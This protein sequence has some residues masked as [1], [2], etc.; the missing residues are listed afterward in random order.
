LSFTRFD[1]ADF[2]RYVLLAMDEGVMK[3][4]TGRA[5]NQKEAKNDF[6]MHCMPITKILKRDFSW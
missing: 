5:L 6:K 1:V 3:Y 2:Q 4:I